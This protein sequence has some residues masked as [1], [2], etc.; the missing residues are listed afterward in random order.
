MA[1]AKG[2]LDQQRKNTRSTK[3]SLQLPSD[4]DVFQQLDQLDPDAGTQTHLL[5]FTVLDANNLSGLNCS[6]QT[7]SFPCLSSQG[8]RY[9]FA[10]YNYDSNAI[11]VE[12]MKTRT[13]ASIVNAYRKTHDR[14]CKSGLKPSFQILDNECSRLMKDFFNQR[15]IEFQLV[16]P[17]AH[18]RNAAERAI[19]TFK[20]HFI[21]ILAG[22]DKNFPMH[23]WDRLLFQAETTL[24]M[25]R[26]SRLH[27]KLSADMVINGPF[28][29]NATPMAPPGTRVL[30][31]EPPA[32]RRSFA[33]HGVEGW[34]ISSQQVSRMCHLCAIHQSHPD[35]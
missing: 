8:N 6:D 23:L 31:H 15:G 30:L 33:P 9:I 5:N 4:N 19:R 16:T 18:R 17:H 25:L 3:S 26:P 11:L 35:W 29:F 34:C 1:T 32:T 13:A 7:G 28:D 12:P 27:P 21:A 2:H 24:N 22:T 14:L 20:C 10:L